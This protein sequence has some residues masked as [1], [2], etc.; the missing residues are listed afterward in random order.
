M[1]GTKTKG[2]YI[3]DII[4]YKN[5]NNNNNI[6]ILVTAEKINKTEIKS[7]NKIDL[8]IKLSYISLNYLDKIIENTT[9][10]N[11]IISNNIINI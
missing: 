6:Q 5:K 3:L 7:I 10:Y 9:G 8:Y 1:K 2:L 11:N 4:F